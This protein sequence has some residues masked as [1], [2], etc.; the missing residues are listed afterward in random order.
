M[1]SNNFS[2]MTSIKNEFF[3]KHEFNTTD[4]ADLLLSNETRII[5]DQINEFNSTN[6]IKFL[7]LRCKNQSSWFT[8]KLNIWGPDIEA[9]YIIDV[10]TNDGKNQNIDFLSMPKHFNFKL[11]KN[12]DILAYSSNVYSCSFILN[13]IDIL[14][15]KVLLHLSDEH[16]HHPEFIK[17]FDKVKLV[18]RQYKFFEQKESIKYLPLGYHSYGKRYL[19][20]NHISIKNKCFKWCFS[21]SIKKDRKKQLNTLSTIKPNFIGKTNAFESTSMFQQSIFA[22]CPSGN[23][24]IET[25]RIYEAMYNGCIPLVYNEDPD[26]IKNFKSMFDLELPCFFCTSLEDMIVIMKNKEHNIEQIRKQCFSWLEKQNYIIRNN[27]IQ[28][29]KN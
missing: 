12:C 23:S 28:A 13:I 19:R 9:E 11:L 16:G 17:A 29:C 18:Y 20:K 25:F 14:K 15:P 6:K 21:G 10:L 27:I 5:S 26:I 2:K 8:D 22:F 4:I 24:N 3:I 7:F 1:E